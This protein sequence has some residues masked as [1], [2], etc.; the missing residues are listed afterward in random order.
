MN[1]SAMIV[2]GGLLIVL[3]AMGALACDRAGEEVTKHSRAPRPSQTALATPSAAALAPW[4]PVDEAFR[5]CES[6]CGIRTAGPAAVVVQPGAKPGDRTY[7][8]VSGVVFTVTDSSP[9]KEVDGRSIYVCCAGCA[10]Y[11]SANRDR[12]IAVRQLGS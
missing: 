11:F 8:P 1:H 4:E 10:Q 9:R 5:G 7:C 12:V 2:P 3:A 6:S